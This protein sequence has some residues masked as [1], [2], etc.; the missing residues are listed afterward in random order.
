ME[1]Q[2]DWLLFQLG[3]DCRIDRR[4]DVKLYLVT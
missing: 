2:G 1:A 3:A 4:P